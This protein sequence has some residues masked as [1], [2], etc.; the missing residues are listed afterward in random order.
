MDIL[1]SITNI[2][3]ECELDY[4]MQSI[5]MSFGTVSGFL[6]FLTNFFVFRFLLDT[7]AVLYTQL[8]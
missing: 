2:Y 5:G 8:S 1:V 3:N 4:F 6:N 7:D